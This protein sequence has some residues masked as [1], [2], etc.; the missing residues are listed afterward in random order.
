MTRVL[1]FLRRHRP[2]AAGL[3]D[4]D[5]LA[6]FRTARDEGLLLTAIPRVLSGQSEVKLQSVQGHPRGRRC[7]G[8][9]TR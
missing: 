2:P 1:D 3:A 6:R 4:P 5:L 9:W 7:S 8:C